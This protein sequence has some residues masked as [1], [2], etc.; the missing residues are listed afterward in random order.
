GGNFRFSPSI[1]LTLAAPCA[2][3]RNRGCSS[4]RVMAESTIA[5]ARV[6]PVLRNAGCSNIQTRY[7][8]ARSGSTQVSYPHLALNPG[9]LERRTPCAY[10]RESLNG[11]T[12]DCS[13]LRLSV[14]SPNILFREA[15]LAGG[16][17]SAAL[18]WLSSFYKSL[19]GSC[20][21]LS[22]SHRL[23]R[24]GTASRA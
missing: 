13:L 19:R 15:P 6:L 4:A 7:K 11:S 14:R 18:P 21:R 2:G 22:T 10:L 9:N 24:H 17:S 1:V 5:T 23:Q 12:K 20:S 3:F 8:A 16:M